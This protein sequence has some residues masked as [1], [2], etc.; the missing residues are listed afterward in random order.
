MTPAVPFVVRS[1]SFLRH[2][3]NPCRQARLYNPASCPRLDPPPANGWVRSAVRY[4][5]FRHYY[6]KLI[7]QSASTGDRLQSL[8]MAVTYADGSTIDRFTAS[9]NLQLWRKRR[10]WKATQYLRMNSLLLRR[11]RS[12]SYKHQAAAARFPLAR[13]GT[14]WHAD[15][16]AICYSLTCIDSRKEGGVLFFVV[17]C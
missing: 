9:K 16:D 11:P 12:F 10:A 17:H 13:S 4:R 1:P 5:L 2:H 8:G 14:L 6:S 15:V 7:D 3:L